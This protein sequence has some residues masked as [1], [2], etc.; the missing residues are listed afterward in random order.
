MCEVTPIADLEAD[1]WVHATLKSLS[2]KCDTLLQLLGTKKADVPESAERQLFVYMTIIL[3]NTYQDM[4]H[5]YPNGLREKR[6][7]VTKAQ[8][9]DWWKAEFPEK[10]S[11]SC[12]E[13][14]N[15]LLK[16]YPIEPSEIQQLKSSIDITDNGRVSWFEFDVF[17]RLFQPWDRIITNWRLI[18]NDHPG[19]QS[20]I[21]YEEVLQLLAKYTSKPGS[22][23]FRLSCT[24]LGQW[25]IGYVD[26]NGNIK[27]TIPQRTSLYQALIDGAAKGIYLYPM[28]QEQN[29][30]LTA[31]SS[32]TQKRHISV[33]KEQ[34][35][36]YVGMD[37]LFELCKICTANPKDVQIEPCGHL[38]CH[39]CVSEWQKQ[40]KNECPFCRKEM[41]ELQSV[42]VD[43]YRRNSLAQKENNGLSKKKS[44]ALAINT[45]SLLPVAIEEEAPPPRPAKSPIANRSGRSSLQPIDA[46]TLQAKHSLTFNNSVEF[47]GASADRTHSPPTTPLPRIPA[48]GDPHPTFDRRDIDS[49]HS[50]E[51]TH[52]SAI[53]E[54]SLPVEGTALIM[55]GVLPT[56]PSDRRA[57]H[58]PDISGLQISVTDSAEQTQVAR[59]PSLPVPRYEQLPDSGE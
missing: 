31:E 2:A 30:D 55:A 13:F 8:A 15:A 26:S 44:I 9:F 3:S 50:A 43:P 45:S 28:G 53:R 46:S 42:V 59:Q 33:S 17:T 10:H 51:A 1:D 22:Y 37:S 27:Q 35:D 36:M 58:N 29:V 39:S 54:L 56:R 32:L 6:F 52:I 21:T 48:R 5:V 57:S 47:S 25:A 23:V 19:F 14:I 11:V 24:R 7:E 20:Y 18:S 4:K 16:S 34:H 12:M 40:A 38:I 41:R 49:T